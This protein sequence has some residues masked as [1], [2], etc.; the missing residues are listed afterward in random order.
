MKKKLR[1][2][3]GWGLLITPIMALLIWL[4]ITGDIFGFKVVLGLFF[5]GAIMITG[6]T[7]I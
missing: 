5:S 2:I 6:V 4:L 7:L 1:K 3:I